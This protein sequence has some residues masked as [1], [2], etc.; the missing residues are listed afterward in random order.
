MVWLKPYLLSVCKIIKIGLNR[1]QIANW[2]S[3]VM[4]NDVVYVFR[5]LSRLKLNQGHS[6]AG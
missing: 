1:I 5:C 4:V 6:E 2:F 3:T